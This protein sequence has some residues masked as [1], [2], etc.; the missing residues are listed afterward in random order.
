YTGT[1]A[2]NRQITMTVIEP[3]NGS[4]VGFMAK[5]R[6]LGYET[7]EEQFVRRQKAGREAQLQ[8]EK[9]QLQ[10][11]SEQRLKDQEAERILKAGRG[12]KVCKSE[13]R[14]MHIGFV[15]DFAGKNIQIQVQ[16]VHFKGAPT[17][18]PGGFTP[19]IT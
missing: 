3:T 2:G 6:E 12:S 13:G 16:H 11:E 17:R 5:A 9:A 1:Y 4:T 8:Y 10:Y 19:H 14:F 18:R 7:A 15:N